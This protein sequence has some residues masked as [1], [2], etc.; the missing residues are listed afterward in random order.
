MAELS[1]TEAVTRIER[2]LSSEYYIITL[3]SPKV[4]RMCLSTT[5]HPCRPVTVLSGFLG[6]GKTTL[7]NRILHNR[8][9]LRVA[10]MVNDTS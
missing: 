7:L 9:C 5:R 6:E 8:Q 2:V 10:V 3:Y 1:S 4:L